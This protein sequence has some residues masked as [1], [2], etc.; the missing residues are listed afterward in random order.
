[1][2]AF[3]ASATKHIG[4]VTYT[5]PLPGLLA[6]SGF[7]A[8]SARLC[9]SSAGSIAYKLTDQRA[10]HL[11]ACAQPC[12]SSSWQACTSH[13]DDHAY[14]E[15]LFFVDSRLAFVCVVV[16]QCT[17]LRPQSWSSLLDSSTCSGSQR[18]VSERRAYRCCPRPY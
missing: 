3:C 18:G 16:S 13:V 15:F 5:S 8:G 11:V 4:V 10:D 12:L 17:S 9:C 7:P 6:I 1:M 2:Q 14:S